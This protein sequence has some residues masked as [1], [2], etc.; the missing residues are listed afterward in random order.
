MHAG[1]RGVQKEKQARTEIRERQSSE[2][3]HK[4]TRSARI[5]VFPFSTHPSSLSTDV[6]AER[7]TSSLRLSVSFNFFRRLI[8]APKV[9]GSLAFGDVYV[10]TCIYSVYIQSVGRAGN[11]KHICYESERTGGTWP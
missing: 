6:L 9:S 10:C 1:G 8:P 2:L 7:E 4:S 3:N 11:R 5:S